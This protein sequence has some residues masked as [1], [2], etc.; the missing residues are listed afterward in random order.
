MRPDYITDEFLSAF[1]SSAIEEDIHEGDL[2][3]KA[4]V[5]QTK[6][7]RGRLVSKEPGVIAGCELA[8][9]IF[10]KIDSALQLDILVPDGTQVEDGNTVFTVSGRAE[11]ILTG[12]R[13]ALNCIQ[14]MSGIATLT[15][16]YVKKIAG[17]RAAIYDTRKTTPGFRLQ[18]KWAVLLGGGHNHRLG[19]HDMI[20]IKD[21]HI[22]IAGGVQA[23]IRRV[24][25]FVKNLQNPPPI[26]I[27]A[28]TLKEVKEIAE[29]GGV[30]IVLFDNMA[31]DEMSKAVRIVGE[32]FLTEASGG[33]HEENLIDVAACGVHRISVGAITHGAVSLDMNLKLF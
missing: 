17:T 18:E 25:D 13:L 14:R 28:R 27:E 20:L 32:R 22:D 24:G 19:L 6:Q 7:A 29:C 2:T 10:N 15:R 8:V 5:G 16:R 31:V 21:N 11:S 4:I 1:V 23:A 3:T 30:D 9:T 12:E 26:E 33:I